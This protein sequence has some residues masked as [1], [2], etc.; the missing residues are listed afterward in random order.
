MRPGLAKAGGVPL[1]VP[2]NLPPDPSRRPGERRAPPRHPRS[3]WQK[4][5]KQHVGPTRFDEREGFGQTLP[6]TKLKTRAMPTLRG[7]LKKTRVVRVVF[8]DQD[9]SR[10]S[11]ASRDPLGDVPVVV[12]SSMSRR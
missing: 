5:Q 12:Q 8:R 4:I 9:S 7:A 2:P 1:G 6:V 11:V 10:T 3:V